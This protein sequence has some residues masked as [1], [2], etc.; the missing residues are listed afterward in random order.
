MKCPWIRGWSVFI[1]GLVCVRGVTG[2]GV[3]GVAHSDLSG[4][5]VAIGVLGGVSKSDGKYAGSA[6]SSGARGL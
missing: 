1:S 3:V 4:V 2:V 5:V 6:Q